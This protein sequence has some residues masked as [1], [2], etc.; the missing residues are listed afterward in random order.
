M[1]ISDL[2][3]Q[4]IGLYFSA[5]W[6]GPCRRFTPQL[7]EVYNELSSKN[8]FEVVFVSADRDD[9]SFNGYFSKMPW[10]ALPFSA[11]ETRDGLDELFGVNGIPHL[12]ILNASGKISTNDGVSIISNYGAEAY[13]FTPE[14]IK[15]LNEEEE[16]AKK[17]QTL[18]RILVSKSRNFLITNEGNQVTTE[19]LVST[20]ALVIFQLKNMFSLPG[21]GVRARRQ[22]CWFALLFYILRPLCCIH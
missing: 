20:N 19:T 6:C 3:G 21:S 8:D 18:S 9:E 17:D 5:S 2:S 11:S 15:E 1:K 14:K 16:R 10:L 7:I 13:P 4:T 22:D 12:V